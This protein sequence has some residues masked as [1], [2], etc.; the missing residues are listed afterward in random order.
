MT[1]STPSVTALISIP[2][3]AGAAGGLLWRSIGHK[4][5]L[6]HKIDWLER[7]S[8]I[9]NIILWPADSQGLYEIQTYAKR[10]GVDVFYCAHDSRLAPLTDFLRARGAH[11]IFRQSIDSALIPLG[12]VRRVFDHFDRHQLD[13]VSTSEDSGFPRG[14]EMEFV[15]LETLQTLVAEDYRRAGE[16]VDGVQQ[17]RDYGA[18]ALVTDQVYAETSEFAPS[19]DWRPSSQAPDAWFHQ[20]ARLLDTPDISLADLIAPN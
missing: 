12:L 10:R 20:A 14:V 5:V 7:C 11:V 8:L 6:D 17:I 16:R 9:K 4:C 3:A 13:Y 2:S 15:H 19:L 1:H 18:R